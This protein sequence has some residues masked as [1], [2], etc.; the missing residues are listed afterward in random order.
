M[1]SGVNMDH[2]KRKKYLLLFSATGFFCVLAGVIFYLYSPDYQLTDEKVVLYDKP[3]SAIVST[4][5]QSKSV[6]VP[7]PAFD[8][9]SGFYPDSFTLQLSA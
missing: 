1:Q 9:E 5:F 4:A 3:E 8:H 2:K 6:D 7:A